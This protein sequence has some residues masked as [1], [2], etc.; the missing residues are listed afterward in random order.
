MS[1]PRKEPEP[2]R[3]QSATGMIDRGDVFDVDLPEGGRHPV[4]VLTRQQAIP[5]LSSVTVAMVTTRIRGHV[6]EVAIGPEA[7]LTKPSAVNCDSIHTVSK[8]RLARRR[9]SASYETLEAVGEAVRI[10]LALDA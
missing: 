2:S 3:G 5:V 7:G 4:L 9:G 6:A 8:G 1:P 10:A